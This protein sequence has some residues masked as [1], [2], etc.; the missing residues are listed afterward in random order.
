M[1]DFFRKKK[2]AN[3]LDLLIA[4][5]DSNMQNNYKD[6]AQAALREFERKLSKLTEDGTLSEG[7]RESY[8]GKLEAYK[9]TLKEYSH[10]DQKPYWTK[11]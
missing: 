1:F 9:I 6:A 8:L 4:E 5:I 2:S 7:K 3:E 11:D 10:K